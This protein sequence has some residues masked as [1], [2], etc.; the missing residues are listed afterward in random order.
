MILVS[1]GTQDKNFTRLLDAVDKAVE[2]G[3]IKDKVIVQ[4]GHTKYVSKNLEIF[5]YLSIDEFNNLLQDT[6]LLITHG[7]VGTIMSALSMGKKIIGAPRLSKYHEHTNDHQIQLLEN[8]DEQG[9]IVYAK[10]LN[11]F[12]IYLNKIKTFTPKK[13]ESNTENMILLV[14][15]YINNN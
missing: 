15:N 4:A 11:N 5:D 13:Y 6:D 14:K 7:G 8:F 10:D 3:Y 1:L 9:Y 12:E 2:K